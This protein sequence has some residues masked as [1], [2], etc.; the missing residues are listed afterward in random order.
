[1]KLTMTRKKYYSLLS[2]CMMSLI[3]TISFFLLKANLGNGN[4]NYL[5]LILT[6]IVTYICITL[7]SK[8]PIPKRALLFS[9]IGGFIYAFSQVYATS[10]H[11][12]FQSY[13]S[14]KELFLPLCLAF[15]YSVLSISIL[16]TILLYLSDIKDYISMKYNSET[17]KY[18][19]SF[20]F[21]FYFVTIFVSYIPMFLAYYPIL[22]QYDGVDQLRQCALDWFTKWHPLAHTLLL[23]TFYSFGLSIGNLSLGMAIYSILQMATLSFAF[24]YCL[25]ILY[26]NGIPRL[27]RFVILCFFAIFPVNGIFAITT[28]KDVFFAAFFLLFILQLVNHFIFTNHITCLQAITTTILGCLVLLFR[29]NAIYTLLASLPILLFFIKNMR[30]KLFA[31]FVGSFLSYTCINNVLVMSVNAVDTSNITEM[32]SVPLMQ[33]VKASQT[34]GELMDID[35][36]TQLLTYIPEDQLQANGIISDSVKSSADNALICAQPLDFIKLWLEIGLQYPME[37]I[38]AFGILTEGYWY[39]EDEYHALIYGKYMLLGHRA[40]GEGEEIQKYNLFPAYKNMIDGLFLENEYSEIPFLSALCQPALYFW[41]L[42][43]YIWIIWYE[44]NSS[45]FIPAILCTFYYA[46]LFLGPVALV[47]Y[48]YC[49]I[50]V[51]PLL[52]CLLLTNIST[53]D[54]S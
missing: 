31:I 40:I 3:P 17:R 23:D 36:R 53:R 10:L 27:C 20:V 5:K 48:I 16:L 37:Y 1:M 29:N 13:R 42:V 34:D 49:I 38:D 8:R 33:M 39:M 47:R 43:G 25:F 30:F 14:I 21:M 51:A 35:L 12:H 28:T 19:N 9:V 7:C 32:L 26:Q 24:A 52:I 45:L 22:L 4:N 50:V 44:K 11:E 15:G 46:T 6:F 41:I 2:I 54:S 18:R